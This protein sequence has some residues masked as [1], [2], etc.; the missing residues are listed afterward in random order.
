ML[1]KVVSPLPR[2]STVM[3]MI[4]ALVYRISG[5]LATQSGL[6]FPTT[7]WRRRINKS[8]EYHRT[9]AIATCHN[10]LPQMNTRGQLLT[11]EIYGRT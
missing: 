4:A 2:Q 10:P 11:T 8:K 3:L 6:A 1:S 5:G 7:A 9:T